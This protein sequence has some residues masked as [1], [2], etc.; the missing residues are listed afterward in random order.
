MSKNAALAVN[1]LAAYKVG[2]TDNRPWGTYTVTGVGTN[3]AGEEYCE[4]SITVNPGQVLSLQSHEHRREHWTV[5]SGVLTVVS[6]DQRLELKAGQDVRLPQGAIHC[7]AN[8][9]KVPCVVRELQEGICR[10]DDIKRYVDSYGRATETSSSPKAE[11]S[12][13]LYNEVLSEIKKSA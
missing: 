8:L 13:A 2:D 1:T 11:A 4:K 3:K 12:I 6:D 7:M 10:E 5:E 9:G